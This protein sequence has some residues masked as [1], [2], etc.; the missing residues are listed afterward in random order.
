M[1]KTII[2]SKRIRLR[3]V[4]LCRPTMVSFDPSRHPWS[5]KI[6]EF[7]TEAHSIE[8]RPRTAS[9]HGHA[10]MS[11]GHAHTG[12]GQAHMSDGLAHMSDGLAHMSHGHAHTGE[13]QAHMSDGLAHMSD[14]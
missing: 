14:G 10:H 12:D 2:P 5:D 6:G 11:D 1:E 7:A 4:W 8:P 3:V 9:S 13:C